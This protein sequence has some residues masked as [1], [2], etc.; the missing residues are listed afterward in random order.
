[1]RCVFLRD[2]RVNS[3]RGGKS[4]AGIVIVAAVLSASAC[5]VVF[6]ASATG[7]VADAET[8]EE[9]TELSGI[10]D[11]TVYLYTDEEDRDEDFASILEGTP[12]E[13]A[14]EELYFQRTTTATEGGTTGV[15]SFYGL[16]WERLLP[17]FG[18]SGDRRSV[19][20]IFYHPEYATK[21]ETAAV[22]NDV[23]NRFPPTLLRRSRNQTTIRGSLI[24]SETDEALDA[25]TV[26][27]YIPDSWIYDANGEISAATTGTGGST[28]FSNPVFPDAPSR[29]F[30]TNTEGEFEGEITYPMMPS[31]EDNVGTTRL[32][33]SFSRNGYESDTATDS[34][35]RND[36][37]LDGD[38]RITEDETYYLTP[39]VES[40][41]V[42][43]LDTVALLP[44]REEN[45][46]TIGG[47]VVNATTGNG[48]EGVAVDIRIPEERLADG[49]YVYPAEADTTLVTD[50]E[51]EY[52]WDFTYPLF[53]DAETNDGKVRI[54]LTFERNQFSLVDEL[55]APYDADL[56]D[57]DI[58][59]DAATEI[60][61]Q[62]SEIDHESTAEIPEIEIK[63]TEFTESL[64]G[65]VY[66]EA[67]GPSAGING[68]Q[69]G[70]FIGAFA[71][72]P[73]DADPDL[74]T[75]TDRRI[76]GTDNPTVRDGFF[77]LTGIDWTD[78]AYTAP[79]SSVSCVIRI[80]AFDASGTPVLTDDRIV[81]VY[82]DASNVLEV[83]ITA[84]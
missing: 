38:A 79:Q 41:T 36:V 4:L 61:L 15:Y 8:W 40:D 55:G 78:Y 13:E 33:I 24:D 74:V 47:S 10:N 6:T 32:L 83:G 52:T 16:I 28:R 43:V 84:P 48:V 77:E 59:G 60:H 63:Q 67:T 76:F 21:A 54:V 22:V 7:R 19:Y 66:D 5:S 64:D 45:A 71:S 12:P 3:F 75:F 53:P 18:K 72:P 44:V 65:L 34:K 23:T 57:A 69:I 37:D 58:F 27:L 70:L 25:V 46:A 81:R 2:I 68:L 50:A 80:R 62:T 51:G 26:E 35:L 31:F 17:E 30:V 29:T 73:A 14:T 49:T 39:I 82:S 1:M 56:T 20:L 42:N 9:S 11:V